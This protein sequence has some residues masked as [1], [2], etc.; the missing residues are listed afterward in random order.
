MSIGLLLAL[1]AFLLDVLFMAL[2]QIDLKVGG[3]I[4]LTDLA[5]MFGGVTVPMRVPS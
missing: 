3:L 2:G 5:I 1:L 4:A